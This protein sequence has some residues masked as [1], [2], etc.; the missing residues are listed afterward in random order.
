MDASTPLEVFQEKEEEALGTA[1]KKITND[2]NSVKFISFFQVGFC[3]D[4]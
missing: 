3:S 2:Q 1:H 4:F